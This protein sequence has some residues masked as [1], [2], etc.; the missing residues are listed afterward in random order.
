MT[1]Q[2]YPKPGRT[3]RDGNVIHIRTEFETRLRQ[4]VILEA[5]QQARQIIIRKLK[6]EGKVRVSLMSRAS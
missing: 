6:S 3:R 4:M 1:P 2:E 5:Q